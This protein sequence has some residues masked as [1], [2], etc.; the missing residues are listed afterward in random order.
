MHLRQCGHDFVLPNSRYE[1]NKCHFIARS[2]FDCQNFVHLFHVCVYVLY[3]FTFVVFCDYFLCQMCAYHVYFS[4]NL[5]PYIFNNSWNAQVSYS[6]RYHCTSSIL[7]F[8]V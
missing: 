2:L 1:F 8:P 7:V 3:D 4:I 5:L 6:E